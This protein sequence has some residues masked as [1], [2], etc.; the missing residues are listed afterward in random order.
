MAGEAE[1]VLGPDQALVSDMIAMDQE[2]II[3]RV[4]DGS[5]AGLYDS[6]PLVD[7]L[8]LTT[9]H[10][11]QL[12]VL[13]RWLEIGESLGGWKVGMTSGSMRD[14][15]GSG[16][17]PFG[18]ILAGRILATDS[19]VDLA[20]IGRC[21]CEPELA[22]RIRSR[23]AGY[24]VDAQQA[25][26]A[27]GGVLPAFEINQRRLSGESDGPVRVADDLS[28]WGIV[29]GEEI[30]LTEDF[31]PAALEV[32][33]RSG[34]VLLARASGGPQW[35]DDPFCSLATLVRRLALHGLGLE[36]GQIVLT[37]AFAKHEVLGPS[38]YSASFSGLGEVHVAFR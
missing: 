22:L 20:R 38:E 31:D 12:G 19:E 13:G 18:F 9:A 5:R 1:I 16:V 14:A 3:C 8:N 26:E 2:D 25:R 30:E 17:R 29:V 11:V 4:F 24:D 6:T 34:R 28:Q 23:L 21:G 33:F 32:E 7:Q 15:L 36:P 35:I 37:G 27:V 10:E